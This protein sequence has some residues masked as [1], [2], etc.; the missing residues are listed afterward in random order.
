MSRVTRRALVW[1][2]LITAAALFAMAANV[3][4]YRRI[5]EDHYPI[6]GG[7]DPVERTASETVTF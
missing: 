3:Y 6:L 2:A 4:I 5:V 7:I 1:Y